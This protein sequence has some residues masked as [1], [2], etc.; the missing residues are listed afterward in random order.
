MITCQSGQNTGIRKHSRISP[1]SSGGSKGVGSIQKV[2]D[3]FSEIVQKSKE[4]LDNEEADEE[5]DEEALKHRSFWKRV[6]ALQSG[7]LNITTYSG[8]VRIRKRKHAVSFGKCLYEHMKQGAVC[9]NGNAGKI[10]TKL[11]KAALQYYCS[12][13][14]DMDEDETKNYTAKALE[15]LGCN[16][17]NDAD[18]CVEDNCISALTSL[19]KEIKFSAKSLDDL[20]LLHKSVLNNADTVYWVLMFLIAQIVLNINTLTMLAP[21]LT[22]LFG[23]SFAIGPM[24]SNVF[25]ALSFVIFV[26]PYDIDHK[27]VVGESRKTGLYGTVSSITLMYTTIITPLHKRV[28]FN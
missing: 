24:L 27:I 4:T 15:I 26:I 16:E 20:Q 28:R 14:A 12:N 17:E 21:L 23:V 22:I 25:L 5:K 1:A 7:S 2:G 6:H 11:L 9:K 10:T 19:Y 13:E 8:L 18:E 3:F